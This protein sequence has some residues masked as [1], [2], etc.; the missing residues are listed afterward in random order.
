MGVG[1]DPLVEAPTATGL[2]M[3]GK[4]TPKEGRAIRQPKKSFW[5]DATLP[6]YTETTVRHL[7]L[8]LFM[9]FTL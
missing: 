9:M 4:G 1:T 5:M 3:R 7:L 2:S 8:C 6:F